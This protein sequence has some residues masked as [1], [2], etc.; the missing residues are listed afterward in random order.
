[1]RIHEATHEYI[2]KAV[3]PALMTFDE[4]ER[5]LNPKQ[6]QHPDSAYQS[7]RE[8]LSSYIRYDDY[9]TLLNRKKL[10]P[11]WFEFRLRTEHLWD[12]KLKYTK[13][14]AQ[15]EIIRG[16]NGDALYMSLEDKRAAGIP[17]YEFTLA[18]FD[19]EK[20]T[21]A[22]A[23]N[24]WDCWLFVT[25]EEYK[26]LGLGPILGRMA[27]EYYPERPSGGF[28]PSG[29]HNLQKIHDHAVRAYLGSGMYSWLVRDGQLTPGRVREILGSI[30]KWQAWR[31][32][33][34]RDGWVFDRDNP[35]RMRN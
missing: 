5:F 19:E 32:Q 10:G 21:A 24:E 23:Q 31:E 3:D 34:K 22:S 4:Y 18:V 17:Q 29:G 15:G 33:L 2:R 27:R 16:P 11:H 7:T 9:K 8:K 6:K 35:T 13:T 1:M 12:E 30:Q 28:T 25:V 14:D 20:Q 26:G